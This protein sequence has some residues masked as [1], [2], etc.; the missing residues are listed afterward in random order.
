MYERAAGDKILPSD[1]RPPHVLKA[2]RYR[3]LLSMLIQYSSRGHLTTYFT[4][5]FLCVA[6]QQPLISYATEPERFVTT[7]LCNDKLVLWPS[8]AMTVVLDS[9]YSPFIL[10]EITLAFRSH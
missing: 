2:S 6:F 8:N 10:R 3:Y 5:L 1:L 4:T 7:L 9:I